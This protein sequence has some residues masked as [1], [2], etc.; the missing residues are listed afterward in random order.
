MTTNTVFTLT[1][2][3]SG[4][5]Y[6]SELLRANL[7]D[8]VVEHEPYLRRGNP[9]MFGLPIYDRWAGNLDA[10]RNRVKH[11]RATIA[12]YRACCY[13]E[14]SHAFLKSWWDVA[15]EFFARMKL[16]HLIRHPLDVARSEANREAFIHRWH[17]PLRNYRGRDGQLYFFW[18]L[19]GREPIFHCHGV[20]RVTRFQH[21]LLQWIEIENRAMAF[22]DR[23][24]MHASCMT[25]HTPH[26]LMDAEAIDRL[27]DFLGL[28]RKRKTAI[29]SRFQNRTPGSLT[30][31]GDE[32]RRQCRRI[33]E[34]LPPHHLE[35]FARPPY[36]KYEWS[37]LVRK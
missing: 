19:T 35:I 10:V 28:A 37:A 4:T 6:L 3:R 23:F 16:L 5:R 36:V 30:L 29:P 18:A 21:Y 13:I 32:E 2:G 27:P 15:P 11:K 9:T 1:S 24:D 12:R 34:S 14:T 8:V 22:L 26:D 20:P 7:R 25:L 31:I 33:I 17:L